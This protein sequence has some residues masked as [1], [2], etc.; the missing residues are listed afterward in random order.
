MD[1]PSKSAT[2]KRRRL[3]VQRLDARHQ[4]G[5][6]TRGVLGLVSAKGAAVAQ[7]VAQR[8]RAIMLV[9]SATGLLGAPGCGGEAKSPCV[10]AKDRL[11]EC[12]VEILAP[13]AIGSRLLPLKLTDDCGGE[14]SCVA[15][16]VVPAPCDAIGYVVAGSTDPNEA[17]PPGAETFQHCVY[18]ATRWLSR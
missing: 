13:D 18:S 16:C 15:E 11:Q 7:D 8:L 10:L 9:A 14:N 2:S 5:R 17:T 12:R 3:A 6:E 1:I 4:I